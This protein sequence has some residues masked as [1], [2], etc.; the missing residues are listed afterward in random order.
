[1]G[2]NEGGRGKREKERRN[3]REGG[4]SRRMQGSWVNRGWKK[5]LLS[6]M[7]TEIHFLCSSFCSFMV[8]L[9]Q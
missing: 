2:R 7:K 6:E 9:R 4:K 5:G 1:M 3:G 8:F